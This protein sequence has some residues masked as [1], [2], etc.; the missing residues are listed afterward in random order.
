MG[1]RGP[2]PAPTSL[3]IARGNPSK[4]NLDDRVKREPRPPTDGIEPPAW[5]TGVALE[6]WHDV[7]PRLQ[8]MKCVSAAD[9]ETLARYCVL[10]EQW[11]KYLDQMRRG[12]DVL[13][14][15]D[16]DGKVKYMQSSPAATMFL[17]LGQQMLRIEQEFGLTPSSRSGISV[18]NGETADSIRAFNS[19]A[20]DAG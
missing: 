4:E 20:L 16:S 15:R 8:A 19:E 18:D 13:V 3:K 17:K 7:L 6:K 1:K 14:M 11:V 5:V 9:I 2:K 12:L 10:H